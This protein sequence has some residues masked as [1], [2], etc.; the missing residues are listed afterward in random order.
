MRVDWTQVNLIV[1]KPRA[2]AELYND[3]RYCTITTDNDTSEIHTRPNCVRICSF[4]CKA[5]PAKQSNT[6]CTHPMSSCVLLHRI[7]GDHCSSSSQTEQNTSSKGAPAGFAR[8][9]YVWRGSIPRWVLLRNTLTAAV[10]KLPV[11]Y[12]T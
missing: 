4:N 7:G 9:H 11:R 6:V 5:Y 2:C 10:V 3:L 8:C 12:G 1:G